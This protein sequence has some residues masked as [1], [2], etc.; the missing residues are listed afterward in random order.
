MGEWHL[1]R[2]AEQAF[3]RLGDNE[4]LWFEGAWHSTGQLRERASRIGNGLV[5][6]GVAPGDRVIVMLPNSPTVPVV[7]NAIWRA[8]AAMT[9]LMFLL[10]PDEVARIIADSEATTAITS[11][12]FLGIV[13]TAAEGSDLKFIITTGPEADGVISLD[14]L[15]S[16]EEGSIV[17]RDDS[18]LSALLY[19]GGT[20][21]KSKGVMYSHQNQAYCAKALH[22]HSYIP[23]QTMGL[24]ALPL[25]HAFGLMVTVSG[26]YTKEPGKAVLMS[27]F[28][29]TQW[30]EHVQEFK[31]NRAAAVPSMIQMLLSQPLEDYDLSS[32][33]FVGVGAAPLAREVIEQFE[34]RVPSCKIYEGYGC[35]ESGGGATAN[36]PDPERRKVG[37]VGVPWPGYELKIVKEDDKELP[38]G[39][40]GEVCIKSPGLMK[41][42]WKSEELTDEVMRGGWLHT[43]DVGRLD[44]DGYLY[45]VDRIK[46][47]IIRGGFNVYPRDVEDCLL[48]HPAVAVAGVV[49]KP[50]EKYGEEVVAFVQLHPGKEATPEELIEHCKAKIGGYKYPRVVNVVGYVPLTPVGKVD[51]K[52]IRAML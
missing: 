3:E 33:E 40:P 19:T 32:W 49:G 43:G 17:D 22:E 15:E 42:Y 10:P 38:V 47:L 1:A 35:T 28:D 12:E 48:E 16:A 44:E 39:E 11:P 25:S 37:S 4:A 21:G 20:T 46:D 7:Y 18:D 52:A 13:Q 36:P 29:P 23:G 41:G 30:L 9:P 34:R 31:V 24:S 14:S 51:R 8:G 26:F 50:D 2:I 45:I 6:L 5:E 27:W